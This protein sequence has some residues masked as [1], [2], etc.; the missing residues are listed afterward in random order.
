MSALQNICHWTAWLMSALY[1]LW[2]GIGTNDALIDAIWHKLDMFLMASEKL[3][4]KGDYHTWIT[5]LFVAIFSTRDPRIGRGVYATFD[6]VLVRL[7]HVMKDATAAA[8]PLIQKFGSCKDFRRLYPLV[9]DEVKKA[10]IDAYFNILSPARAKW[11]VKDNRFNEIPSG[12]PVLAAKWAPRF[13]K[14]DEKQFVFSLADRLFPRVKVLFRTNYK[15]VL[16]KNW[17]RFIVSLRSGQVVEQF[18][19]DQSWAYIPCKIVPAKAMLNYRACLFNLES[20]AH[21]TRKAVINGVSKTE[22]RIVCADNFRKYFSSSAK[23]KCAGITPADLAAVYISD[24]CLPADAVVERQFEEICKEASARV[25]KHMFF[26]IC[27]VSGSMDCR[28]GRKTSATALSASIG[29]SA[30]LAQIGHPATRNRILT[31]DSNPQWIDVSSSDSFYKK[32]RILENA[33]WG[34]TTNFDRAYMKIL[35]VLVDAKVSAEEVDQLIV[36]CISDMQFDLASQNKSRS[37]FHGAK[38]EFERNGYR[39]PKMVFINVM[40]H[41]HSMIMHP[42]CE[43]VRMLSGYSPNLLG[44]IL[45]TEIQTHTSEDMLLAELLDLK[46]VPIHDVLHNHFSQ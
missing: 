7:S 23:V 4:E 24:P 32:V 43:N 27:D 44:M 18:M 28:L 21:Q 46:W 38:Q 20:G 31:F 6:I 15:S 19:C 3:S 16:R 5:L 2:E 37:A 1:V 14:K 35:Q 30:L 29:F 22:D 25:G 10:L 33:R 34:Y 13:D 42:N 12:P 17:N 36:V 39:V 40:S 41:T 9:S 45:N 11:S 26:P 8:I